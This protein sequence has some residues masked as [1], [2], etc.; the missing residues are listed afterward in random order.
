MHITSEELKIVIIPSIFDTLY[1]VTLSSLFALL[2]G[3][4]IGIVLY[5]TNPK[6]M[7]TNKKSLLVINKILSFIVNFGR[8]IPFVIIIIAVFPL[9]RLIVGTSI[10]RTAAIVPLTIAAIPFVG[11]VV[12]Q[13]FE[14]V[15]KGLIEY[16]IGSGANLFLIIFKVLI[17]ESLPSLIKGAT[18]SIISI[19]GY[20][21]MAGMVGGGGLGDIANRYGYLRNRSDILIVTIIILVIYVQIVQAC[22]TLLAKK[23]NKK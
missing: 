13:A 21:A 4:L 6:N 10:G 12:E 15:N 8:S 22:G 3:L 9:A 16:A 14:E 19:I 17:K 20:S 1:L 23:F 18:L 2:I 7:F 11:R 5:L